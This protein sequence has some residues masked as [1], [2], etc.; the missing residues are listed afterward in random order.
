MEREIAVD[1]SDEGMVRAIEDNLCECCRSLGGL[2]GATLYDDPEM[3]YVVTGRPG[4]FFNCVARARL[5]AGPVDARV[6]EAVGRFRARGVA[7]RWWTGPLTTPAD[8]GSRLEEHGFG[9]RLDAPG[10]GLDLAGMGEEVEEPPGVDIEHVEDQ[11]RLAQWSFVCSRGFG[12][13]EVEVRA[14]HEAYAEVGLGPELPWQH[15]VAIREGEP[16]ATS[17]LFLGGGV[18][19][20]YHVVTMPVARGQGIGAAVTAVALHSARRLGYRIAVLQATE[21]GAPVYRRLGFRE[22]CTLGLYFLG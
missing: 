15:F 19:G 22:F 9:P 12:M 13:G 16:V 5:A 11:A 8:L 21:M 10:M 4:S 6:E 20:L 3:V 7:G 17:S 14:W 1:T 18:A 2:E